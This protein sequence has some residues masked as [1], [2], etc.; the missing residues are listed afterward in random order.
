MN[1]SYEFNTMDKCKSPVHICLTNSKW[2]KLNK[3]INSNY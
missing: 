2:W 3:Y 1:N